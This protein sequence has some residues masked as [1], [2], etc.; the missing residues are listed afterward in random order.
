[1]FS[2]DHFSK[3]GSQAIRTTGT[4]VGNLIL[5]ATR[6][7]F[8]SDILPIF[9]LLDCLY[10]YRCPGSSGDPED[11]LQT[12][13]FLNYLDVSS[14]G[15]MKGILYRIKIRV[16]SSEDR[17]FLRKITNRTGLSLSNY[18]IIVSIVIIYSD[19]RLKLTIQGIRE[20]RKCEN[21][22]LWYGNEISTT[23]NIGCRFPS[24]I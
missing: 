24:S 9:T 14:D 3:I 16:P 10:T 8:H 12:K 1:M 18:S 4:I 20:P 2:A 13:T 19:A 21:Y 5:G 23:R 17:L 6:T 11:F 22:F 7:N 15:S